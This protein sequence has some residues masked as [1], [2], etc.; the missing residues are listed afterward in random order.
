MAAAQPLPP[1]NAAGFNASADDVFGRIAVR[2]DRL[3]DLFSLGIHRH[4]KRRVAELIS[5]EP[6]KEL[7]DVACGTGDIVLRV[8]DR[9]ETRH[10]RHV[11]ASDI[12][13]QMLSVAERRLARLGYTVELR[14]KDAHSLSGVAANSVDLYSISLGLKICD[15]S[16]VLREALRVLRPGGRLVILEASNIPFRWLQT[17]YI[18]YMSMCMP[19]IGW[20]VT[21]GDASAYRYL[22]QGIRDFP[23]AERLAAELR[24]LGFHEVGFER[25]SLGIVA[26]HVARKPAPVASQPP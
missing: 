10:S 23:T 17:A 24:D 5:R 4:W 6:W 22:L 7:L 16:V 25:L 9:R 3:C 1:C 14:C 20:I 12:S 21:G 11:M 2:Y 18:H 19:L 26:I 15:R 8:L 13:R